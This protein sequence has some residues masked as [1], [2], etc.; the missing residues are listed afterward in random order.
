MIHAQ[1]KK[2]IEEAARE[3]FESY[4]DLESVRT[5]AFEAGAKHLWALVGWQ[6]Y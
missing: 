6:E 3:H 4:G 1:L 2:Q 5:I